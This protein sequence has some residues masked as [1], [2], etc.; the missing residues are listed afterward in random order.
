MKNAVNSCPRGRKLF[1]KKKSQFFLTNI[2]S[3]VAGNAVTSSSTSINIIILFY[4]HDF[5]IYCIHFNKSRDD[6]RQTRRYIEYIKYIFI[7]L[8]LYLYTITVINNFAC[9]NEIVGP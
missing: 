3:V 2:N 5:K 8:M 9:K 4:Y 7:I 1:N 6:V